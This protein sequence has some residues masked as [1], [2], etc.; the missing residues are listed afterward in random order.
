MPG[1]SETKAPPIGVRCEADGVGQKKIN[2]FLARCGKDHFKPKQSLIS[3][4]G[5]FH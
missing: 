2:K 4:N 3:G 1:T 5:V